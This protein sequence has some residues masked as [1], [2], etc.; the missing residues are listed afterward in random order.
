MRKTV[1]LGLVAGVLSASPALAQMPTSHKVALS[2]YATGASLDYHST[3]L[4]LSHPCGC[5]REQNPLGR[6]TDGKPAATVAIGAAADAATAALL[7]RWL[8]KE[9]PSLTTALIYAAASTRF[10]FASGNYQ[11]LPH[12]DRR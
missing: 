4:A 6:L 2:V 12:G 8:G 10:F 7:Y 3:Y 9:H 5:G 1:V 11:G